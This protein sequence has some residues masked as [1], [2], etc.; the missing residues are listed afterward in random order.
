MHPLVYIS[1]LMRV[2][3]AASVLEMWGWQNNSKDNRESTAWIAY[4]EIGTR[5]RRPVVGLVD[6]A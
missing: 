1:S 6:N 3:G 2:K 5:W 4:L